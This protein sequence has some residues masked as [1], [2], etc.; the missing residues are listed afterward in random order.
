LAGAVEDDA[1][2]RPLT[3]DLAQGF[4]EQVRQWSLEAGAA[5]D[6]AALAARAARALSLAVSEG[7]VCLRLDDL[8][9]AARL[10]ERL[11]ASRV[12]GT[13]QAPGAMPLILDGERLYLHRYFDFERRLAHRLAQARRPLPTPIAPHARA[14]LR[15][16]FPRGGAP[17]DSAVDWQQ[18]ASALALRGALTVV[19]GAPGTGKTSTV[20]RLLGCLLAQRADSRIALAA[21]TGKAAARLAQ[22]VREQAV[23]LPPALRAR[24]P[25]EATTVHRLLGSLGGS[26]FR[27]HAG[28]LLPVDVL[29]V[30][31]ASMLSL[32]LAAQLL[33]AVP[34]QARIVLLGDKDQLAAVEPGAVFAELC[35][36]PSLSGPCL[37]EIAALCGVAP[38]ALAPPAPL[39]ATGLADHVVWLRHPYRFG[40]D[41]ALGRLAQAVNAGQASAARALLH[42]AAHAASG[43]LCWLPQAQDALTDD[44]RQRLLAGY[45]P[46]LAAL[47]RD[48]ADVAAV[49]AAFDAFRVLAALR[50]G[51]RG[52]A[53]LN[54]LVARQVRQA[55]QAPP[56]AAW[57]AGRAV[58]VTRNDA[59]TRL[60]NGDVGIALPG[61]GGAL[62]V[63]FQDETGFRA[64][65]PARLPPHQDAFALTVHRA[66]G[67]ELDETLLVLPAAPGPVLSRELLYTGLTR[68]RRR[69]TLAGSAAVV[70]SALR[71]PTRRHS[72]L[73]ARL[74]EAFTC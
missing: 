53:A 73:I 74:Q 54:A 66:Q 3:H 13:P 68:A 30:D 11:P 57:Y 71:S 64:L 26:R 50:E 40:P 12:A 27:H 49:T 16:L 38:A 58:L 63:F 43:A 6:D 59:A 41:S 25:K 61:V 60:F 19:S 65:P 2:A 33:E 14:L 29:V 32:P 51:E 34:P 37:R 56:Q 52:V 7:H 5:E 22:A 28:Q 46:F 10:R 48:P 23:R 45:A 18:V 42:E 4:A 8:A 21:P 9:D 69:V 15:E 72:G 39:R 47:R 20:A 55:V 67:S 31:E 24:L 35:A 17:A 44:A 62:Q 36:D 70:E 1:P